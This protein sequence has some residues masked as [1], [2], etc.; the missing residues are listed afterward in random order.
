MT[1]ESAGFPAVRLAERRVGDLLP[2]LVATV[3][4]AGVG[5]LIPLLDQPLLILV[6]IAIAAAFILIARRIDLAVYL[7]IA[8]TALNRYNF[9][10]A[11]WNA[12]VENIVLVLV[13]AA[14][15]SR[16]IPGRDRAQRLPFALVLG[17]FLV[18]NVLSSVLNSTDTYK[19][20][21]IVVRMA[22]AVATF[23][24]IS[25]YVS[26]RGRLLG[27]LR[28]LLIVGAAASAF[29]VVALVVWHLSGQDLGV[30]NNPISGAVSPTG[31]LWEGNIFGSY[32]A[33][34]AVLSGALLLSRTRTFHRGLLSVVFALAMAALI[35]SLARGAWVGFAA[36]SVLALLFLRRVRPHVA[37]LVVGVVAVG[38]ALI[39]RSGLGGVP[40]EVSARFATLPTIRAD[41][42]T[43]SRLGNIDL[44]LAEWRSRP[45]LGW[46]TDGFHINHPENLSALPI[47]QLGALYDTGL[48]GFAL[49]VVFIGALL[50]RAITA[51]ARSGDESL[52]VV[53]GALTFAAIAQL[54]AFQATDAF[55][56]GFVWVYFGLML[57]AVRLIEEGARD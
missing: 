15:A 12:K 56:L 39:L 14:W 30:Q 42:N 49:F 52:A 20:M 1:S 10:L 38:L 26:D 25:S 17:S 36:G 29:G 46:G 57:G 40:Q 53:L 9:D 22:L 33:G 5:A 11:G 28:T 16:I 54:I 55:W 41:V 13:L 35:L 45:V 43:V 24:V 31:T 37:L 2:L 4:L 32:A 44:A 18:V 34:I 21:R 27:A 8:T 23:Y 51:S 48:V 50:F 7:L 6:P 47:P 3:A 19:S